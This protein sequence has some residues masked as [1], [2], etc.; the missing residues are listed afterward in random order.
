MFVKETTGTD[1]D[2]YA[3][4]KIYKIMSKKQL[5]DASSMV[6]EEYLDFVRRAW[7][8]LSSSPDAGEQLPVSCWCMIS[9]GC[10]PARWS[11]MG[12]TA[13]WDIGLAAVVH[14]PRSPDLMPQD[15]GISGSSKAKLERGI[16]MMAPWADKGHLFLNILRSF[17]PVATIGKSLL[18]LKAIID[19]KGGHIEQSL[20]E[21]KRT[22]SGQ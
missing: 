10:T 9:P 17:D 2:G 22:R 21:L 19:S 4:E 7:R 5:V 6:G 20:G 15:Y 18:R 11:G 13:T 12:C 8:N 1:Y 3:P 14:P 16:S